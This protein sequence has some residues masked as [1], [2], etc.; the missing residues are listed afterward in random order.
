MLLEKQQG[1]GF[2]AVLRAEVDE[3]KTRQFKFPD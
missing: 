2:G 1:I 3:S